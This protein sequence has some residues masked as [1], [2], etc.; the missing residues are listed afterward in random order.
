[1]AAAIALC[2]PAAIEQRPAVLKLLQ[3]ADATVR[4]KTALALVGVK[5]KDAVPVLIDLLAQLPS[6]RAGLAEDVLYEL[7]GDRAPQVPFGSDA[8]GRKRYREAWAAWWRDNKD[9]VDLAKLDGVSRGQLVVV[10]W[11]KTGATGKVVGMGADGKPRWEIGGLQSP[12]DAQLLP[13]DQVLIS[14]YTSKRVTVRNLKGDVLWEK[15]LAANQL[16]VHACR[17]DNGNIFIVCRN[18]LL[19]VNKDGKEVLNITRPANDNIYAAQ[20]L[21]D[22]KIAVINLKGVYTLLDKDGKDLKSFAVGRGTAASGFDVQPDGKVLVPLYQENKVVE[23][24]ADG[25]QTWQVGVQA[26]Y[27][28][29]RLPNGNVLVCCPTTQKIIEFDRAGKVV[30]QYELDGRPYRARRR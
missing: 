30:R 28:A 10:V 6:D 27:G 25:K 9:K 16:L 24:D 15:K 7:A 2:Q 21:K 8:A 3:D 26:P 4:L 14:E 5:E 11:D 1:M 18:A 29:A 17:L 19:E 22:G 13:N 23:Y 12:R 20:K